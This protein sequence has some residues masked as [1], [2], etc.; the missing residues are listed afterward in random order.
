MQQGERN[1]DHL[2]LKPD[3]RT[4]SNTLREG[5]GVQYKFRV[6]PWSEL[7]L[8]FNILMFVH[9]GVIAHISNPYGGAILSKH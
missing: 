1:E 7:R 2:K 3:A 9:E 5:G 6:I 8:G 4:L